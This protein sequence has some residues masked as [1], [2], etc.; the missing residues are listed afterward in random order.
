MRRELDA[1]DAGGLRDAGGE[2]YLPL[3]YA[4]RAVRRGDRAARARSTPAAR[5]PAGSRACGRSPRGSAARARLTLDPTERH[6]FE[7]QS[8]FGFTL[9][10]EGVRGTL[11]RGGTYRI[12]RH[13]T[14]PATGFSLYPEPLVEA[15]KAGEPRRDA[16][17]LPLGHDAA[18][19]AAKLRADGWRTRRGAV[20]TRDDAAALG[21]TPPARWQDRQPL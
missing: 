1:K 8:W 5:S 19:A 12:R 9:Y 13:A 16:L 10:A 4:S 14:K 2:A 21:C 17:F 3:L 18:R 20:A 7:Y 6:G 11:G 15:V